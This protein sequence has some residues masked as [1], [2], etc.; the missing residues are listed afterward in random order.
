MRVE[1]HERVALS[2]TIGVYEGPSKFEQRLRLLFRGRPMKWLVGFVIAIGVLVGLYWLKYPNYSYRYRLSVSFEVDGRVRTGSSVIEVTW[3]G[4]PEIGDV[5]G[6]SSTMK[7]EAALVDLGSHGA[8]VAT[9]I[10]SDSYGQSKDGAWGALWI[11]PRAFGFGTSVDELPAFLKLQGKRDLSA[12]NLPRFLWFSNPQDLA[13][14]QKLLPTEVSMT[15]GPS[16]RFVGASV[17]I[18]DDPLVVD[19][20][21][22]LSWIKTIESRPPEARTIYLPNKLGISRY[23]FI[24][25]AS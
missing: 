15:L 8:V 23:L 17:E 13:T 6:Y 16:V 9:L 25:D 4:G 21:Q 5:G 1:L 10:T 19:I 12:D 24:G 7:G 3:H 2:S 20:R 18:T 14:A 11:A 22:K